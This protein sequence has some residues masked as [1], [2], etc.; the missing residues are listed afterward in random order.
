MTRFVKSWFGPLLQGSLLLA[1][2]L[3]MSGCRTSRPGSA[4]PFTLH[5]VESGG[6]EPVLVAPGVVNSPAFEMNARPSSNG[7]EFFFTRASEDWK[8]MAILRCEWRGDHWSKP[9]ELPFN[10]DFQNADPF[11]SPDGNRLFFAS[12]R[13]V[14]NR[15]KGD[16]DLWVVDRSGN[17][18]GDPMPLVSLNSS[19][20]DVSPILVA[21]GSL[22]FTSKREGG[23]GSYDVY[24]A[25]WDGE[26]FL[27]PKNLL[28]PVN[29]RHT[30]VDCYVNPEQTILLYAGHER[31]DTLGKGDI[32][33]CFKSKGSWSAPHH[34]DAPINSPAM[35]LCPSLSP[36]GRYLFFSSTRSPSAGSN[37]EAGS[38]D[39][40]VVDIQSLQQFQER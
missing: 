6:G 8:S 28:A 15:P 31:K 17:T 25:A 34:L 2:V 38:A 27:A 32:Y 16:F 21:D 19:E 35:E 29:S 18:W 24:H 3:A 40:Y 7:E 23:L 39:I 30:E 4:G 10:Q 20:D 22:Y 13:D 37:K 14:M 1:L 5:G 36:D 33:V 9:E 11:L 26:H 12:K